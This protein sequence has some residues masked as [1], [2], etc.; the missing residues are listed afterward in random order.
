MPIRCSGD[1]LVLSGVVTAEE[2][3]PLCRHL[4][5]HPDAAVDLADCAHL[6]TAV[7]QVLLSGQPRVVR[8]FQDLFLL[9]F[10]MPLLPRS[11]E[12]AV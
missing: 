9:R 7:L 3:E 5:S 10:V 8:P 4:S 11:T 12:R 6:H 1:T 2:A